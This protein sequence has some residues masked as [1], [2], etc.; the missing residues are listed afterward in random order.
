MK[1]QLHLDSWNRKEHFHFFANMDESYF[2]IVVEVNVTKAYAKAKALGISFFQY[3]LY[4][5]LKAANQVENFRYRIESENV[6]CYDAVHA[7]ATIGRED[8]TFGFSFIEYTDDFQTFIQNT[9][10]EIVAVQQTSGLRF[11]EDARRIDCIHYSAIP[12]L[13]FTS[14]THARSFAYRDSAPKISFG[15]Y[16][17]EGDK[18]SL[19]VAIYVHHGLMDAYHVGQF[20]EKFQQLLDVE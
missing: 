14:L 11:N 1:T 9:N 12:W 13:R 2:G 20:V 4:Q 16:H 3:Y 7:S 18:M 5:S 19:P 6:F 17:R 15:K 8:G 10:A